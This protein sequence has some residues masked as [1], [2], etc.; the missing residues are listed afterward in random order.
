[1]FHRNKLLKIC[2]GVI[3]SAA[4]YGV[5]LWILFRP[6][7]IRIDLFSK[8]GNYPEGT[9]IYGIKWRSNYSELGI[10]L[11]NDA[12]IDYINLDNQCSLSFALPG[13]EI[14]DITITPADAKSKAPSI[15]LLTPSGG[16]LYRMRC[17]R[18][19]SKS[20]I[21]AR[22]AITADS[23]QRVEPQ[24]GMLSADYEANFMPRHSFVPRCFKGNCRQIPE[25]IRDGR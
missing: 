23:A 15:P 24:W 1:V 9:D 21:D 18:F 25:K 8:P 20:R 13:P 19:A 5:I 3:V 11:F 7:D 10:A 12:N 22:F 16:S 6:P 2:T 17:A 4:V 14:T